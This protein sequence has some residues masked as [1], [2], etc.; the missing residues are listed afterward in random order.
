MRKG[1]KAWADAGFPELTPEN[2]SRYLFDA[3]GQDEFV[4][5]SWPD[6]FDSIAKALVAI[7]TRYSGEEGKTLAR[8]RLSTEMVEEMGGAGTGR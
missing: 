2:K 6:A 4:Q 8:A 1:W 7:S 3:R 5:I